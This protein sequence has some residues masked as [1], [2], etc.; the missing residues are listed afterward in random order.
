M[1]PHGADTTVSYISKCRGCSDRIFAFERECSLL[2]EVEVGIVG[3]ASAYKLLASVRAVV[4]NEYEVVL[5]GMVCFI[6]T[7]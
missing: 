2:E 5:L 1:K 7:Q 3:R 6:N 4:W